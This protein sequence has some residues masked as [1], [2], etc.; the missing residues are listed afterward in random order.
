MSILLW[1]SHCFKLGPVL[2]GGHAVAGAE[3]FEKTAVIG[4]T[5][6]G[7]GFQATASGSDFPAAVLHAQVFYIIVDALHGVLLKRTGKMLPAGKGVF[8]KESR[9]QARICVVVADVFHSG[10]H[11]GAG[12]AGGW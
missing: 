4:K 6:V 1:C 12:T 2:H 5:T 8:G 11:Q 9:G 3:G 10:G 7:A